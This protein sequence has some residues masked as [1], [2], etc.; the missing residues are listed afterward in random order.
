MTIDRMG[1]KGAM[2]RLEASEQGYQGQNS[3]LADRGTAAAAA[4]NSGLLLQYQRRLACPASRGARA[5]A[6]D[7]GSKQDPSQPRCT[8]L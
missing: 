6:T 2:V 5:L 1:R 7:V 8:E 3:P 4:L